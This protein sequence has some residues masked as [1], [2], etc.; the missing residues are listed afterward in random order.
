MTAHDLT[1]Q[2]RSIFK[3]AVM[4]MSGRAAG[5]IVTFFVPV[6]L[7]RVFT[8]EE[9]GTY[10]QLFLIAYTLFP[11]VQLCFAECLFYFIPGRPECSPKFVTNSILML[12]VAGTV[13]AAALIMYAQAIA[14]WMNNPAIVDY[15]PIIGVYLVL[16]MMSTVLEITMLTRKRYAW[17]TGTYAASDVLRSLLL[18]IPAFLTRSLEW[19]LIGGILFCVT[20]LIAAAAYLRAEFGTELGLDRGL[21]REQVIYSVPY[22]LD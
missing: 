9:F 7:A 17:A 15:M 18:I 14:A 13:C 8:Q 12:A 16:I 11:F 22:S 10:K 20:R 4:L 5:F 2:D 3:P 21:L 19:A 1:A 6:V